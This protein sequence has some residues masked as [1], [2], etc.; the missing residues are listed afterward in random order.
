MKIN[1]IEVKK[2]QFSIICYQI[3]LKF[4]KLFENDSRMKNKILLYIEEKNYI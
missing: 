4:S 3:K 2:L 1:Y